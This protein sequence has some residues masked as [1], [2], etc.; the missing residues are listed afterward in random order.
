MEAVRREDWWEIEEGVWCEGEA[1]SESE[2][3]GREE[4]V[5]VVRLEGGMG[6]GEVM[7]DILQVG[8]REVNRCEG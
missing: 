3:E 8:G 2:R 5:G 4:V 1:R 6:R 7:V